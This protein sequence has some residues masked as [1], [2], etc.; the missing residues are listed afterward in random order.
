MLVVSVAIVLGALHQLNSAFKEWANNYFGNYLACLLET[1]ELPSLS[2]SPGDSGICNELFKPFNLADGRKLRTDV[3]AGRNSGGAGRGAVQRDRGGG[4]GGSGAA[5][6]GGG[7]GSFGRSSRRVAGKSGRRIGGGGAP[8]KTGSTD[9]SSNGYG[10]NT[11]PPKN[12]VP[13]KTTLNDR[14]A[15]DDSRER[16]QRRQVASSP[17]KPFE[18]SQRQA[19]IPLHDK[20]KSKGGG[21]GEGGGSFSFSVFLRF[22]IIAA[23]V[24]ALVMFL[25]GQALQIGK[26]MDAN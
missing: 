11:R 26:S 13:L 17:P 20:P 5:V 24:I 22:L 16:Q 7:G 14:F 18:M 1:G 4:G 2:G 12:M 21:G 23:I 25:G 9:V 3:K 8:L 15:F 19:R 6:T 10:Y